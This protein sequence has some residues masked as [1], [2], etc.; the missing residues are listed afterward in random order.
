LSH[1]ST[2]DTVDP[3]EGKSAFRLF[4]THAS[5]LNLAPMYFNDSASFTC[6]LHLTRVIIGPCPLLMYDLDVQLHISALAGDRVDM[7]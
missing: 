3:S 5:K 7:I 6:D 1:F 4:V 2:A